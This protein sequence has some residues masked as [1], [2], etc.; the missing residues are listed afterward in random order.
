MEVLF[1]S[2]FQKS[3]DKLERLILCVAFNLDNIISPACMNTKVDL[4]LEWFEM[5][6][7]VI[8]VNNALAVLQPPIIFRHTEL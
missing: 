1:V 8:N 3:I 6:V 5:M 2:D 4:R 7:H